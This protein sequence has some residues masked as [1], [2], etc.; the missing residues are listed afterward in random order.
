[1]LLKPNLT[2]LISINFI[3]ALIIFCLSLNSSFPD[4]NDY[5]ALADGILHGQFSSYYDLDGNYPNALRSPGYPLFL[6]VILAFSNNIF[7]VKLIQLLIYFCTIL[8]ALRIVAKLSSSDIPQYTFLILSSISFQIPYYAAL[9]SSELVTIFNIILILYLLINRD[10]FSVKV[11][12]YTGMAFASLVMIKPAFVLLPFTV[13]FIGIVFQR[14]HTKNYII[15]LL[16]FIL[17]CMP[18]ASW[19]KVNHGV[20]KPTTIEGMATIAHMGF[21]NFKLPSGYQSTFDNYQSFIVP[22]LSNPFKNSSAEELEN[23]RKFEKEWGDI[24]LALEPFI[25]DN[26]QND[27]LIMKSDPTIFV[28]YP[29]GYVVEREKLLT[30]ALLKNIKND[31]IYFIKTRTYNFFRVFFTGINKSNFTSETSKFKKVQMIAAFGITFTIIF[32]GFIYTSFFVLKNWR[33]LSYEFFLIYIF[34]IYTAGVHMPFSVQARYSVP[35]HLCLLILLSII[36]PRL[37]LNQK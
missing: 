29:T 1:M 21:W 13:F 7:I 34:I 28:T 14:Q 20:L 22:D 5:L 10:N 33:K 19:N 9:I 3:I 32:C 11:N 30:Q 6:S 8:L 24:N 17:G 37:Y 4:Q 2:F 16:T 23:I 35:I 15:I 12:I 27:L 18:F 36:T 31:P 26:F 25:P